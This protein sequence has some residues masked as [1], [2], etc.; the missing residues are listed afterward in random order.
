M[1]TPSDK[2]EP[3]CWL[4]EKTAKVS[5]VDNLPG[6]DW[7]PLYRTPR[8]TS[9]EIEKALRGFLTLRTDAPGF[10]K[11]FTLKCILAETALFATQERKT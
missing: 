7:I 1:T 6:Q 8:S 3:L 11:E 9:G 10:A 4:N 5:F 2:D